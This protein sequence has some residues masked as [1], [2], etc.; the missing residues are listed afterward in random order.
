MNDR[1]VFFETEGTLIKGARD[2]GDPAKLR[3][4]PGASA[5][6]ARL[7]AAGYRLFAVTHQ[8]GV[9]RGRFREA[10]LALVVRRLEELLAPEDAALDGFYYCPH[11]PGGRVRAYAVECLCRK[12][13]PGLIE[14]ACREHDLDPVRSWMIGDVLDDVEA[15]RRAGCRS[16]MIDS[17]H[18]TAWRRGP[19]RVPH[20]MAPNLLAAADQILRTAAHERS[21]ART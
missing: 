2:G 12:P 17:G 20:L 16:I 1:A 10:D 4:L 18:E 14:D 7:R 6:L 19:E 5:G 9:A 8:P 13:S 21:L 15:G 3:L 11:Q